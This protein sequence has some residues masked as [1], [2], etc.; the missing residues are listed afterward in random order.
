MKIADLTHTISPNMPVYPGTEQP[1]FIT[2]CSIDGNGFL[3][4]QITMYSH[5]GTHIDAPAHL[6]NNSKT[7]DQ[8]SIGHFYGK[9]YLLNL[10]NTEVQTI[11][12][13]ELKPHKESLKQ[14]EFLLIYTQWSRY[15]GTEK[16]FSDY[17]VLTVEAAR[18]LNRF[19]LKGLGFDTISVDKPDSK[20][21]PIHKVFLQNDTIIIENLANLETLTCRHFYFSCFPLRF[22]KADGS[23][24]RAVAFIP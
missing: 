4:K 19:G 5:T 20:E 9:A 7:L 11:G 17:P 1:V 15:W 22:E 3:E 12:I 18:W 8:M 23:P 24:V 14:S 2:G 16:Y 13:E 6:I 10:T 21:F